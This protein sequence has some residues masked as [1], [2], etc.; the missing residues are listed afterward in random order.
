MGFRR[1][2]I[3]KLSAGT[4]PIKAA[5]GELAPLVVLQFSMRVISIGPNQ[6][7]TASTLLL[8]EGYNP[9]LPSKSTVLAPIV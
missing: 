7:T 3:S 1:A 4:P 9:T 2:N 6:L 5:S 8:K